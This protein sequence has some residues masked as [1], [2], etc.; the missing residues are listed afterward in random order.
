MTRTIIENG[1]S[2][3][4]TP[5]E[6]AEFD[7]LAVAAAQ[8]AT[9]IAA[10]EALAAILAQLAEIDAKSVRPLRAIL[11]TQAAGQTPDPD[12]VTYLAALKAQADT[13]RAQLVA[14]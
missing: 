10:A 12:D 13:L 6:D 14:P 9:E 4:A 8:R 11:D 7:A 2:R 1:V 5:E 3:P